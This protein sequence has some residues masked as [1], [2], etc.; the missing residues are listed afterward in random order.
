MTEQ[1]WLT[2]EDPQR[3]LLH[4]EEAAIALDFPYPSERK[5]R[6]FACACA[7]AFGL[8][9]DHHGT[10]GE[11]IKDPVAQAENWVWQPPGGPTGAFVPEMIANILRD[12]IGS[13]Y[14]PVTVD[15][16]W[17]TP[18]V[19]TLAEAAYEERETVWECRRH[20]RVPASEVYEAEEG[21]HGHAHPTG[22]CWQRA[23]CVDTGHLDPVR[24]AVLADALE[25][26]G[27]VNE[28]ILAHLRSPGPHYRGCLVLDL[29]LSK[30]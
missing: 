21:G 22:D 3:M 28:D 24:L 5:L 4:L 1:E 20:G 2:C 19:I 16:Q 25:E 18:T 6:L 27:C 12:I 11:R 26:A 7:C 30:E 23:T 13:P 15:P 10:D 17:L 9:P 14:R 29:L 8:P